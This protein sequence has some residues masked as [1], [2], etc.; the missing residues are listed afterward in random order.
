MFW[1]LNRPTAAARAFRAVIPWE[2]GVDV[3]MSH[4]E[5]IKGACQLP[6]HANRNRKSFPYLPRILLGVVVGV[7]LDSFV[8]VLVQYLDPFKAGGIF[9]LDASQSQTGEV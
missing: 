5:L 9:D 4:L 1:R 6:F 8:F 3:S 2:V 7:Q